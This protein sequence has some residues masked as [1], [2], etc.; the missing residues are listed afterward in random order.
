MCTYGAKQA[1]IS[2]LKK[3]IFFYI[4]NVF[5]EKNEVEEMMTEF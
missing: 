3:K 4:L 5:L 2:F 1:W